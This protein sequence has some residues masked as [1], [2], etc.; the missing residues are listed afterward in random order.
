MRIK[1]PRD[2][3]SGAIFGGLGLAFALIAQGY[4]FGTS[5]HMG[6]GYFPAILGGLL[7]FLGAILLLRSFVL[8][9]P[10][11][12]PIRI[13]GMAIVVGSIVLFGFIYDLSGLVPAIIALVVA[14]SFAGREFRLVESLSLAAVLCV[15]TVLIFVTFL[16]LPLRIGFGF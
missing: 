15:M 9:G 6:P 7:A 16:K 5:M 1:A 8:E 10:P 3:W 4:R 14:S 2:F 12:P 13:G 11:V